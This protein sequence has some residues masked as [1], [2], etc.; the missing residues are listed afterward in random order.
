MITPVV[1]SQSLSVLEQGGK[2]EGGITH[3]SLVKS[4]AEHLLRF[5]GVGTQK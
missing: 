4:S 2:K 5:T 1:G 3:G